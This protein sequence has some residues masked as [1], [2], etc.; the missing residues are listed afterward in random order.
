[1]VLEFLDHFGMLQSWH[2]FA[3]AYAQLSL[4]TTA[5]LHTTNALLDLSA[6]VLSAVVRDHLSIVAT[7]LCVPLFREPRSNKMIL[8]FPLY[9]LMCSNKL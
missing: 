7:D 3:E 9:T 5:Y 4:Q 1:M 6:V 8:S 2:V